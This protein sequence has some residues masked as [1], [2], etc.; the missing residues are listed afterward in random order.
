MVCC[1]ICIEGPLQ[2]Y[3]IGPT[4]YEQ[5]VQH[6]Q[7]SS[8]VSLALDLLS[9]WWIKSNKLAILISH[10]YKWQCSLN[11]FLIMKK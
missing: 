3:E 9:A 4:L 6:G 10:W 1:N 7:D 5:T 11:D 2:E 8:H